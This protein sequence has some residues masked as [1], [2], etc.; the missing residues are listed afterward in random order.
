MQA[1]RLGVLAVV[2]MMFLSQSSRSAAHID[3]PINA[4]VAVK[5]ADLTDVFAWM[6][7]DAQKVNFIL[8]I[9]RNVQPAEAQFM[10]GTV[11]QYVLHTTSRQSFGASPGP[12][13]AII[14]TF[15]DGAPASAQTIQCWVGNEAYVTG[16]ANNPDTGLT[17]TDGKVRVFAGVRNDSFFFNLPGFRASARMVTSA[18]AGDLGPVTFDAAGCPALPPAFQAAVVTQ[19]QNRVPNPNGT[20]PAF[21][22]SNNGTSLNDFNGFNV[23]AIVLEVDK[24][25]ITKNGALLSVWGSTNRP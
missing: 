6:S 7:P 24:S 5:A 14:C 16:N 15:S 25:L 18:L 12:E 17:S 4:G 22:G 10:P 1:F 11:L 2:A 21:L 19:L 23:L 20:N 8:S 13:I 9:G 3:S